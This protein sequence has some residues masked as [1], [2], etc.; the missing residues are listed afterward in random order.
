MTSIQLL[1]RQPDNLLIDFGV[2]SFV[3]GFGNL[4]GRF[5]A[6]ALLP[7]KRRRFVQT[8]GPIT[9]QIVN[10]QFIGQLVNY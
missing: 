9:I 8:V 7:N 5:A 1:D 6:V 10:K 3:Q 2:G 4:G